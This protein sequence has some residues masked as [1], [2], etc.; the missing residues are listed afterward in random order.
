MSFIK[1]KSKT[2]PINKKKIIIKICVSAFSGLTFGVVAAIVIAALEPQVSN[3]LGEEQKQTIVIEAENTDAYQNTSQV[4][5]TTPIDAQKWQ[6]TLYAKGNEMASALVSAGADESKCG[7]IF[8][9]EGSQITILAEGFWEEETETSV[10]FFDGAK[11]TGK[12]SGL[13]KSTGIAILSVAKAGVPLATQQ[14][15][16]LA[17]FGN[18]RTLNRGQYLIGV[19]NPLGKASTIITGVV[20]GTNETVSYVDREYS[21]IS[22]NIPAKTTAS[23]FLIAENGNV[24][25]VITHATD[26]AGEWNTLT[27]IGISELTD[28]IESLANAKAIPYVGIEVTTVTEALEKEYKLPKGVYVDRVVLNSPAMNGNIQV[29]DVIVGIGK[30]EISTVKQLQEAI[31]DCEP[32]DKI[33]FTVSRQSNGEYRSVI[34]EVIVGVME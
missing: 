7:I 10:R 27:A 34:C 31:M 20:T 1:E 13:D 3:F 21:L 19:G 8:S 5:S 9:M 14:K 32:G 18:S 29:G 17:D 16:G 4:I 30:K 2:K 26:E 28:V 24:V 25:G 15:L 22:T 23:G 12:V 11:V 6:Y 33:K